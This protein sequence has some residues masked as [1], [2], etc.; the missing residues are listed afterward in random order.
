MIV[1]LKT[2]R[3]IESE[4][5]DRYGG[6]INGTMEGRF[7]GLIELNP[8]DGFS[9]ADPDGY[10]YMDEDGWGYKKEWI[11]WDHALL[12]ALKRCINQE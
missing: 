3:Q 11:V 5:S 9:A 1:L 7:G 8:N 10:P 2:I 4:S 12:K 6:Y